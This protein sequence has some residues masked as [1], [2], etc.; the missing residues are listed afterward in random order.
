MQNA[1]RYSEAAHDDYA[2]I[3]E[4]PFDKAVMEKSSRVAI[5]PCDPAWS[6]IGSWESLW[7]ISK[8][9]GDGNVIEGNAVCRS[10]Q[11]C[12]IHAQ[13]RLVACA[14]VK[15]L[16]IVETGDALLIANRSD[17]DSMRTLVK[18]LKGA[19]YSEVIRP[20]PVNVN[21]PA[22]SGKTGTYK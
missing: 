11:D 1:Q 5:V 7:E 15:N 19:G 16:V 4:L 22:S 18:T 17:G 3:P 9:D 8:K 14:G 13:K 6:D 12:I 20:A 2:A 10:T 21:E